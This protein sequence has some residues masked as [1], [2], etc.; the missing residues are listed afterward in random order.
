MKKRLIRIGLLGFGSMGKTHAFCVAN[1]PF[2]CGDLPFKA[3]IY[4]VATRSIE[5]SRAIA[6]SYGF[7]LATDNAEELINDPHVDVIDICTPNHMHADA[8]RRALAAGKHV[9]CEKPLSND[10]KSAEQM[11]AL[12]LS[13]DR[14]CTTV[15]NNR[16]LTPVIRAK[17]LIDQGRLGK[18]LS[19]DF[20]YLH[21]SCTDPEKNAGWKQ[22]ADIC[23]EG[24]VL[25]DLGSHIIDLAL[26]LCGKITH[27]SAK[28]QIAFPQ[29]RGMSGE[30]WQ[31]NAPEAF[32]MMAKTAD[33]ACGT[34]T[35]SK[36]ATGTNDGL[37]F[38]IYGTK[39]ALRFSLMD[40]NYLYF[41]DAEA[42]HTPYGGEAGFTAIECVGRYDAPAGTFPSPK[43]PVGWLR[44]H[45][46]SMYDFLNAV[47]TEQQNSPSFTEALAVQRVMDAALR[48]DAE[49]CEKAVE[50]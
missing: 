25:L 9:Y 18:I 42:P 10:L 29:R 44:G 43:A 20:A 5:K 37:S 38:S 6:E 23:G 2:Y 31:T 14:I 8:L 33:G 30:H 46:M 50:L 39:G 1:L 28:S 22:T 16:F 21:N 45:V 17:Q 4:G 27:V 48:S 3:E 40:P 15:F 34:I 47:Y 41:Y 24:G 26:M 49:G 32:Y 7:S 12:A 19:F 11:A 35:A 36:L 13:H